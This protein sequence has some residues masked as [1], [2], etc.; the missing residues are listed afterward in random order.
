MGRS[1]WVHGGFLGVGKAKT[2]GLEMK[3]LIKSPMHEDGREAWT[4]S[5]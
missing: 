1:S 4:I 5:T 3:N 2:D